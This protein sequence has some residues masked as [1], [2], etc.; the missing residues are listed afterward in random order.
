MVQ[1]QMREVKKILNGKLFKR[2]RF[3]PVGRE[4]FEPPKA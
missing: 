3:F 2:L 1:K 4:G